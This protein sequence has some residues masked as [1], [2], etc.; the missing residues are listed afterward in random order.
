LSARE[1]RGR[2]GAWLFSDG[3]LVFAPY[4]AVFALA[5][6]LRWSNGTLRVLFVAIHLLLF[7]AFV[8]HL[9]LSRATSGREPAPWRRAGVWAVLALAAA[10]ALP[11]AYLEF[12]ADPWE[13]VRRT[14]VPRAE[15]LVGADG[16]A[17][18]LAYLWAWS[19]VSW[20]P[21]IHQR[22]AFD[23]L[24]AFWQ[25]LLA[26]QLY[27]FARRLGFSSAWSRL[28]VLGVVALF[29]NNVF[30]FFRYYA[31]SATPLAYIAYLAGAIAVLDGI[32]RPAARRR[33]TGVLLLAGGLILANHVQEMLFLV[34]FA[35]VALGVRWVT[36]AGPRLRRAVLAT[37]AVVAVLGLGAGRLAIGTPGR[38]GIGPLQD[39]WPWFS[40]VASFRLWDPGLNYFHALGLPGVLAVIL[41]LLRFRAHPLLASLT[42]APPALLLFPPFAVPFA[43]LTHPGNTYR[44]LYAI[45]GS[46]ILVASLRAA[47]V[48]LARRGRIRRGRTAALA[49][50]TFVVLAVGA[51]SGPPVF[52]KLRFQLHRPSSELALVALDE[53]AQWFHDHR[54]GSEGCLVKSDAITQFVLDAYRGRPLG[55]D[56]VTG[57]H[58]VSEMWFPWDLPFRDFDGHYR[59]HL[60]FCGLLVVDE[61]SLPGVASPR[62][63]SWAG[64]QSGH[65][66][67]DAA[68]FG[69]RVPPGLQEDAEKLLAR[70]WTKV[71]V[72]PHYAYYEPP[73]S[74]SASPLSTRP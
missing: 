45:P 34:L 35:V 2:V 72:P 42:L 44:L 74:P 59:R 17:S 31:L 25:L 43:S 73:A 61:A 3:W 38:M 64:P 58:Y 67:A 56:R 55:V 40:R 60:A 20:V 65:W 29:G 53:T 6:A 23:L 9:R 32:E 48:A 4:L 69:A 52:G 15:G 66:G 7:C 22:A 37:L 30:S 63:P 47:L 1:L 28:Q 16:V 21:P 13:H 36:G 50:A 71:R 46:L 39:A 51:W 54:P 26:F 14:N 41:A 19:F 11:G 8:D 62:E 57:A 27:R 12:P 49:A 33:A 70:G 10:L 5:W 24:S 18:R 68:A